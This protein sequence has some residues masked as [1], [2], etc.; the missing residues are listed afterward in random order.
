MGKYDD[1]ERLRK[2]K[3]DGVLSEQEFEVEKRKILG[4][5]KIE[6]RI[7]NNEVEN[8]VQNN[9]E[10]IVKDYTEKIN[11]EK[12]LSRKKNFKIISITLIVAI[13][14]CFAPVVVI[15]I[16][17]NIQKSQEEKLKVT[18][19]NLVGKTYVQAEEELSS[20]GL[21]LEKRENSSDNENA[22]VTEQSEKEGRTI[23]KGDTIK[24]TTKTQQE[25]DKEKEET[26][27]KN[28]ESNAIWKACSEYAKIVEAKNEGSVKYVYPS[29]YGTTQNSGKVYKLKYKTSYE[30]TYYYQLV[31]FNSNYTE[32]IKSTKLFSFYE[33]NGEEHGQTQELEYAYKST[34]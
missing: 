17:S 31:S 1:L 3:D 2:L 12:K 7:P 4:T 15:T 21:K 18:M 32:V 5:E 20:L 27:K 9:S 29:Y 11:K 28:E 25:I 8:K 14:V 6:N 30:N 22:I 13:I 34:F 19:P 16:N 24:I 10:N 33:I 26:N 23:Q